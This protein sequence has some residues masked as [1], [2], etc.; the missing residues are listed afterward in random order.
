MGHI[1]KDTKSYSY[2][3]SIYLVSKFNPMMGINMKIPSFKTIRER[4]LER[5]KKKFNH[6]NVDYTAINLT[7]F[8]IHLLWPYFCVQTKTKQKIEIMEFAS[9]T[10]IYVQKKKRVSE[11]YRNVLQKKNNEL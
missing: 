7:T 8:P 5:R 11:N 3:L 4:E 9:F 1:K 6:Q 2:Y 10:P